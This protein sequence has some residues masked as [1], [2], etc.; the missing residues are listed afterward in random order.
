MDRLADLKKGF[1]ENDHWIEVRGSGVD[2][3]GNFSVFQTVFRSHFSAVHRGG[4]GGAVQGSIQEF[5]NIVEI[6]KDAIKSIHLRSEELKEIHQN[7]LMASTETQEDN[8]I[9]SIDTIVSSGNKSA[10]S[11]QALLKDLHKEY[12]IQKDQKMAISPSEL[13]IRE[14]L[15]T[16]LTRR[17]LDELKDYQNVQNKTKELRTK[18][19]VKQVLRVKPDATPEEVDALIR[20]GMAQ[21]LQKREI[22]QVCSTIM[23]EE[24]ESANSSC[25]PL[26]GI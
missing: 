20:T 11:A 21:Q 7:L 4:V 8:A 9:E 12:K 19:E 5:Y 15:L 26:G 10:K 22:L 24:K 17:Y 2:S 16:T 6:I 1:L 14:N 23:I 13:R 3:P 25:E 18:R